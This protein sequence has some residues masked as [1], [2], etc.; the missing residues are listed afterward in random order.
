MAQAHNQFVQ[1]LSAHDHRDL[2]KAFDRANAVTEQTLHRTTLTRWLD[3]S[4]PNR[5]DFVRLLAD[6]LDDPHVYEAWEATRGTRSPSE[7]RSVVTRFDGLSPEDRER[8]YVEIRRSYL[9]SRFPR[10]LDRLSYRVEVN[11]PPEADADH[12][13]IKVSQEYD[14][15]LPAG[16]RIV[17]TTSNRGLGDA[18]E[19][20]SCLFRDI[21]PMDRD[22]LRA[23]LEA[24]PQ[25]VLAYNHLIAAGQRM[26]THE[27]TLHDDGVFEFDN[28]HV[29]EARVR[30]SFEY[31]FPRGRQV[32]PIKFGEFRVAG[33]VEFTLTLN[34]R[35]AS[36]PRAFAYPPAGRQREW[37]AD[38]VRPD[39]LVVSLGAGGTILADGDGV[40][41]S[42]V[43][44]G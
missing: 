18:Y 35:S 34:A 44:A 19:D 6:E 22:R 20:P 1:A 7:Y 43:E 16:A 39:E 23:L 12:L 30:L 24:G 28:D 29:E 21:I 5:P 9:A 40:V 42:W 37:A 13:V 15:D 17:F 10:L 33:G 14:G 31:P 25:P 32:W 36:S 3:G 2:R 27:S 38:R 26:I 4:V 11:D 8:A 41:L